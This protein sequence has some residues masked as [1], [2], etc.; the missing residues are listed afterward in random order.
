MASRYWVST[1]GGTWD[2]T[3]G[4]KW[5]ATSGG[6]GGASV[7]TAADDV[8]LNASSGSGTVT[9]SS[10]SV[11]RD[12]TCT[13]FTGTLSHPAATTL[14]INGSLTLSAGMTYTL[15]NAA[16]SAITFNATSTGKTIT[17]AGKTIGNITFNGA[18]GGWTLQ[19]D[20]SAAG[21]TITLTAGAFDTGNR[22]ITAS[23]FSSAN[24]N[25]RTLTL[26]SSAISFSATSPGWTTS[27]HTNLT[28]TANSAVITFTGA[29][30]NLL[31]GSSRNWNGMSIV[32]TGSGSPIINGQ[33]CTFA[34]VTRTGTATK[35]DGLFVSAD[36]TVTGT[37]TLSGNS[38][39][40]RLAVTSNT[41]GTQRTIT[42][43]GATMSWSNVDLQDIALSNAYNASAISGG[44]GD[45][46]GNANITFTA[47]ATQTWSGTGSDSWSTNAWTSRMPL[48]QDN[49]VIASAF[50]PSGRVIT[51]DVPRMGASI[52][53]TGTSGNPALTF[54]G[55]VTSN[56]FG[57][58]T[59][60]SAMTLAN[61]NTV[62][63]FSGR[64]SFNLTTAGQLIYPSITVIAPGGSLTM[65]DALTAGRS[66]SVTMG[67]FT[68]SGY[69]VAVLTAFTLNSSTL[70]TLNLGSTTVTLS[71]T[72]AIWNAQANGVLNAGTSNIVL[73]NT[74][75]TAKS[76]TTSG[77][78]TYATVT[79]SGDNI[80]INNA[81]TCTIGTLAVNTAGLTNGLK[82]TSGQTLTVSNLTTNG[83]AGSLA[84]L[85]ASTAG[86]PF[87]LTTPSS[88]I[89]VDYMSIQDST[90]A[91][92]NVWYAGANS[93]NVSGNTNWLFQAPGG[94]TWTGSAALSNA[95]SSLDA[96]ARLRA[97]GASNCSGAGYLVS[98]GVRRQLSAAPM[99]G[100][101]SL[102][103]SG[104][105]VRI[106][107]VSLSGSG[108]LA[109]SGTVIGS[110]GSILGTF[111]GIG[112]LTASG[113]SIGHASVNLN[114]VSS[115]AAT[116]KR[117]VWSGTVLDADTTL[118]GFGVAVRAAMADLSAS[119][120]LQLLV[121]AP[122][123][124]KRVILL[125][126]I[127][128]RRATMLTVNGN[129]KE[130]DILNA[131]K[132]VI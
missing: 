74:T 3:A 55:G 41:V 57:S 82:V 20:L 24:S 130:F 80:T 31:F 2:A 129:A 116:S 118:D 52:D 39:V 60:V 79:M 91:Q 99:T 103:G 19:D 26:G 110:G 47:P 46:G 125:A 106:D 113:V 83:S 65:Q 128:G 21:S 11:C 94:T 121:V 101:G 92:T 44:S 73:S 1:S 71:G 85:S 78:K 8:F 37:L 124:F 22:S 50:S 87:A 77:T 15:V 7:P 98:S 28:M 117:L 14:T 9:L 88:Q 38:A 45:C 51:V 81:G 111:T 114:G 115:L 95:L 68:T 16:T 53:F 93:V 109:A 75:S 5:S 64:G 34:N 63:Q 105:R 6:S 112:S 35:T 69:S 120:L 67:T 97:V 48:A 49:V 96:A 32:L 126:A 76:F 12:L 66:L 36:F 40:N 23:S 42:N 59:L 72:G 132:R 90:V 17:S 107:S 131:R 13:G 30:A 122:G 89:S 123:H 10:S 119:G 27:T 58:L 43:T 108:T 100:S 56:I 102:V 86:N 4:T 62:I 29:S 104:I 54:T 84:K 33:S 25:V 61:V 18:G 70:A 127:D